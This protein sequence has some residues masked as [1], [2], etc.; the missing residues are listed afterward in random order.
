MLDATL[1]LLV[2]DKKICLGIKKRKLGQ[3][4][5]NGFGGK[6]EPGETIEQAACR[7]L[8]EESCVKAKDYQKVGELKY[9]FPKSPQW[10]QIVHVFLV[11]KWEGEPKETEEMG[12]EWFGLDKIPFEKM[13]DNDKIWLPLVLSGKKV[14]GEVVHDGDSTASHSIGVVDSL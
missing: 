14:K 9:L 13:W 4:K 10:D 1:C 12:V 11:T 2:R 8:F 3:G 7:E 6:L 5:Y